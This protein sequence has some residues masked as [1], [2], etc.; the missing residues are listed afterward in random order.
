MPFCP[1]EN[2]RPA[3]RHF[4]TDSS[5]F[6]HATTSKQSHPVCIQCER[7][8]KDSVGAKQVGGITTLDVET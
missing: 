6:K 7:I 3:G 5:L 8:F 1:Y 4:E 2:C